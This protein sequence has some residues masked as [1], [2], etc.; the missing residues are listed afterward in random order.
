VG[1][2][3]LHISPSQF[4]GLNRQTL[5]NPSREPDLQSAQK[6]SL[7][8]GRKRAVGEGGDD[9]PGMPGMPGPGAMMPMPRPPGGGPP[10][11]GPGGMHQGFPSMPT[12]PQMGSMPGMG[13]G[14]PGLPRPPMPPPMGGPMGG[15]PMGNGMPGGAMG[16]MS[17]PSSPGNFPGG[18]NPGSLPPP[19]M[20]ASGSNLPPPPPPG[21]PGFGMPSGGPPMPT[22]PGMPLDSEALAQLRFQQVAA[23]YE[24]QKHAGISPEVAELAEYHSLDE[25]AAKALD[26]EMKKRK[27]TFE[28]DMQALWVGLEGAKNPSGLLMVKLKDMRMGTFRGMS[29]LNGKVQEFAKKYRLDTQAA[30]K[31]GEVL[32]KREDPEGDMEKVGKHLERS[33]KPSSLMMMLLRDLREG[34][35]VKEPEFAAAVGS[36]MHEKELEKTLRRSRSRDRGRR[37]RSRRRGGE[38]ERGGGGGGG[39]RGERGDRGGGGRGDRGGRRSRSRDRRR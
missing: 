9:M 6:N 19:P 15:G 30:V 38:R 16:R 8:M 39:E 1:H 14:M 31:L 11:G 25:R 13:M 29:A 27:D 35:P 3:H 2:H 21:G 24:Q 12:P 5:Y 20:G 4:E 7:R 28:A 34:K 23:E 33:N 22:A 32:D 26:E 10:F 36:K 18:C 37:S 17:G